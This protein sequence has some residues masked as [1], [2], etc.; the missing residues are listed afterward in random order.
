MITGCDFHRRTDDAD[1]LSH[2]QAPDATWKGLSCPGSESFA[3]AGAGRSMAVKFIVSAPL[4][5]DP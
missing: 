2:R 1:A 5:E 4:A 3:A